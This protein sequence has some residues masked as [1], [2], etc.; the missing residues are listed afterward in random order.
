MVF[1]RIGKY[2]N[3]RGRWEFCEL[4][5]EEAEA[6]LK[7][8][9]KDN[10]QEMYTAIK[11]VKSAATYIN[12]SGEEK[13]RIAMA[14]ADKQMM[15]SFTAFGYAIDKKAEEKKKEYYNRPEYKKA[16]EVA[17]KKLTEKITPEESEISKT[18]ARLGEK[19]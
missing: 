12:L 19:K 13:L 14:I 3:L 11:N 2:V 6:V 7:Q 17:E 8:L 10:M 18:F 4:S 16:T 15:S 1:I 9:L 5:L